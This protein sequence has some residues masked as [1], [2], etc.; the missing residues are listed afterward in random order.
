[1]VRDEEATRVDTG[2]F[3]ER[4]VEQCS[5]PARLVQVQQ[6]SGTVSLSARLDVADLQ[7]EMQRLREFTSA[8]ETRV[9]V[10]SRSP[11]RTVRHR[12]RVERLHDAVE[13]LE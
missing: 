10:A 9:P 5:A 8:S 4:E 13:Q 3:S 11:V 12:L 7:L 1:M 6:L 2:Q